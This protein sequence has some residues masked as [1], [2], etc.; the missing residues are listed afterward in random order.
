MIQ[1]DHPVDNSPVAAVIVVFVVVGFVF[2]DKSPVETGRVETQVSLE[3][4]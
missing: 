1:Q 4:Y 3:N 2:V